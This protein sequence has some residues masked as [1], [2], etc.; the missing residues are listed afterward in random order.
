[1][2]A[3]IDLDGDDLVFNTARGRANATNATNLTDITSLAI[4]IVAPDDPCSVVVVR[5]SVEGTEEGDDAHID[6]VA[7]KY[8][9]VDT[10]SI[11]QPGVARVISQVH[12]V[13]VAMQSNDA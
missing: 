5:G 9:D 8:L 2:P 12:A 3:W 13:T 6:T 7:K 11:R 4:S 1:M 10:Y